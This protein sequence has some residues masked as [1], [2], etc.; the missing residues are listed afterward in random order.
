MNQ[1]SVSFS[2]LKCVD[3][4]VW[5]FHIRILPMCSLNLCCKIPDSY[6]VGIYVQS[7]ITVLLLAVYLVLIN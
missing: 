4:L 2:V 1:D 5:Q 3:I 6:A 7:V